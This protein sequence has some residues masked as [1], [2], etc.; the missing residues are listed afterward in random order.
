MR[1]DP[2]VLALDKAARASFD[3]GKAVL[4]L[5]MGIR[6]AIPAAAKLMLDEWVS[7]QPSALSERVDAKIMEVQVNSS[8]AV[9]ESELEESGY[10]VPGDYKADEPTPAAVPDVEESEDSPLNRR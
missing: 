6:L 8:V 2:K 5:R 4:E 10:E 7:A 9:L 1:K 3:R